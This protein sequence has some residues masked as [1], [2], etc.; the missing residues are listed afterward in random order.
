MSNNRGDG[1]NV[2]TIDSS[3]TNSQNVSQPTAN[4]TVPCSSEVTKKRK[5]SK[6]WVWDH[7]IKNKDPKDPKAICNWCSKS[8]AAVSG[9]GTSCMSNHLL[10]CKKYP[11]RVNTDNGQAVLA[12]TP[13]PKFDDDVNGNVLAN[14][15]F[16][17]SECRKWL[18]RMII[19]DELPFIFVEHEG[20]R[21]FCRVMQPRFIVPSRRTIG[22][23][24][25]LIYTDEMSRLKDSFKKLSSRICLTTDS[26]TSIQNLS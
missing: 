16:D 22:R 9:N 3:S 11:H 23:D 17:Q 25:Y 13:V 7:F 8:L 12:F 21:A 6:S 15:K 14:W 2:N 18:A 20:F 26:W 24:C 10:R 19:V 4:V 1:E 5:A